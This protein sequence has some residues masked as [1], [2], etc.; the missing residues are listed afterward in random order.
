MCGEA[1]SEGK[2]GSGIL[3]KG[4]WIQFPKEISGFQMDILSHVGRQC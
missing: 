1:L 3:Y 4:F 2:V